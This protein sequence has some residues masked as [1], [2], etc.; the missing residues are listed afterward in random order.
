MKGEFVEQS[1]AQILECDKDFFLKFDLVIAC[2]VEE[3]T[4]LALGELL[5]E[6]EIPLMLSITYGF[7][8]ELWLQLQFNYLIISLI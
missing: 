2:D 1:A 8:G 4:L 5:W 6:A 3:A 7:I